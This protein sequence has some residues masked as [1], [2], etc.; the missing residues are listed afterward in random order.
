MRVS[1]LQKF[2]ALYLSIRVYPNPPGGRQCPE[3]IGTH[4][5]RELFIVF[6]HS[7]EQFISD[8]LTALGLIGVGHPPATHLP[9]GIHIHIHFVEKLLCFAGQR[10]WHI[11]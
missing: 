11:E 9:A 3:Y 10:R 5:L 2:V 8:Y 7:S 4:Q 6:R 1:D